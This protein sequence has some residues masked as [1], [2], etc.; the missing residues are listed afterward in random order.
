MKPMAVKR[1]FV[2]KYRSAKIPAS[3]KTVVRMR[4]VARRSHAI[5]SASQIEI[6]FDGIS[7]DSLGVLGIEGKG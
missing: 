3:A 2:W 4:T 5:P 7:L 1:N 6:S